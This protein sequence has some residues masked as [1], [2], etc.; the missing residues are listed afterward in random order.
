MNKNSN[1]APCI[2]AAFLYIVYPHI[3]ECNNKCSKTLCLCIFVHRTIQYY[4]LLYSIKVHYDAKIDIILEMW[5][6]YHANYFL[7]A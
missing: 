6:L 5:A 3:P 1:Q 4:T 7:H 2:F